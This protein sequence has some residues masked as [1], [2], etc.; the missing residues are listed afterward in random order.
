MFTCICEKTCIDPSPGRIIYSCLVG[1][2]LVIFILSPIIGISLITLCPFGS[3]G[4]I[5]GLVF[6]ALLAISACILIWGSCC[7][8]KCCIIKQQTMSETND[9]ESQMPQTPNTISEL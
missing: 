6:M 2:T 8:W 9:V 3:V 7:D 1:V 5:I 4:N